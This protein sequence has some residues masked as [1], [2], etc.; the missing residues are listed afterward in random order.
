MSL[1]GLVHGIRE[2][3]P[4]QWATLDGESQ[5]DQ[6]N[7]V[8]QAFSIIRSQVLAKLEEDREAARGR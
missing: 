7:I 4:Y 8:H 5:L 2:S 1:Y 3:G 6:P